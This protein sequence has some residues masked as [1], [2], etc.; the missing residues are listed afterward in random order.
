[1]ENDEDYFFYGQPLG[2]EIASKAGQYSKDIK[3]P[4]S[5]KSLPVWEQVRVRHQDCNYDSAP[6]PSD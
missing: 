6:D 3:D 2:E 5:T 4:A 1:M